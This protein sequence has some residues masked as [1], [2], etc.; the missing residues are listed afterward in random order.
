MAEAPNICETMVFHK[1]LRLNVDLSI[2]SG[3]DQWALKVCFDEVLPKREEK[4]ER[5]E[6]TDPN[7][8]IMEAKH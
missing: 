3:S 7:Q 4:L 1:S 5:K 2:L 8:G 6:N